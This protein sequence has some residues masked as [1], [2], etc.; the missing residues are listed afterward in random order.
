MMNVKRYSLSDPG[1]TYLAE[2]KEGKFVSFEDYDKLL[3]LANG[4]LT[5]TDPNAA[6]HIRGNPLEPQMPATRGVAPPGYGH[7]HVTPNPD[8]S[9]ARCGGPGICEVC[10]G[11]AAR[12]TEVPEEIV[13]YL[14]TYPNAKHNDLRKMLA[15]TKS[16][17]GHVIAEP[18]VRKK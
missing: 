10:S 13:G 4:L 8:G 12:A 18:L 5:A 14:L 6:H 7:G 15:F 9:K 2:D 11:E 3:K 16:E 1:A 17:G